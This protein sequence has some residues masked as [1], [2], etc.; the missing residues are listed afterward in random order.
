ME[1]L[2]VDNQPKLQADITSTHFSLYSA[3]NKSRYVSHL[4]PIT[5][6][7][8]KV[9]SFV[10]WLLGYNAYLLVQNRPPERATIYYGGVQ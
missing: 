7:A 5:C 10:E 9:C 2:L 6:G 3:C 4:F 1:E 8:S